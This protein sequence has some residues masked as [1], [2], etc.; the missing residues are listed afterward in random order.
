MS[1][2]TSYRARGIVLRRTKLGETDLIVT[3]LADR[4]EQ[5]RAVAKGARKPGSKLTG[6]VGL[7]N[8]VD[9]LLHVGK[10]LD[11]ITE[12]KLIASRADC[13]RVF[14][15][16]T[17]M[18][19]LLDSACELTVEGQHDPRLLPLTHTALD[20][21]QTCRI[22]QLA[23]VVAAY[24]LKAVSMQGY[25]PVLNSCVSCGRAIDLRAQPTVRLSFEDGGILCDDCADGMRG[26]MR[27]SGML[28][29]AS[30][31]IG[32]TFAQILELPED[33]RES[34]T[35]YEVLEFARQWLHHYPGIR[36]RA[37]DFV[38]TIDAHIN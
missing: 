24:L 29:W 21:V 17:M 19:A 33:K 12:G 6:V 35:G 10:S 32:M 18:E 1:G 9:L 22:S 4:D 36:P 14:E 23:M 26:A 13:A 8:E 38:F 31:L 27:N 11:I 30:S 2:P 3:L 20:A 25:R 7:G 15:R 28:V 37:L 5:V 16:S 34:A